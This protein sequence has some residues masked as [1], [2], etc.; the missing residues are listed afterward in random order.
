MALMALIATRFPTLY[1]KM[2]GH[3]FSAAD[4]EVYRRL[5]MAEWFI[6]DRREFYRRWG[7]GVAYDVTIPA[8]WPIPLSDIR[9]PVHLWQGEQDISVPPSS[10]RY[11][12]QQI[13]G[14]QATFIPNAGHFSVFEHM[15][16]ILD[17]LVH[18]AEGQTIA[19]H[20]LHGESTPHVFSAD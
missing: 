6:P 7:R 2:I 12:A 9:V 15:G 19:T 13:P 11:L 17:T 14:C 1:S 4:H 5:G 18:S 16:E 8:T 20:P 10:S 3:E